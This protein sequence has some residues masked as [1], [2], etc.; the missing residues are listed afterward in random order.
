[1]ANGS[2]CEWGS[3]ESTGKRDRGAVTWPSR[4]WMLCVRMVI[5]TLEVSS[6]REHE[7]VQG[8]WSGDVGA[9]TQ[10]LTNFETKQK[11]GSSL[12]H[13]KLGLWGTS[14][15]VAFAAVNT[16]Q[17]WHV[18]QRHAHVKVLVLSREDAWWWADD[19]R[20]GEEKI[21]KTSQ[22]DSTDDYKKLMRDKLQQLI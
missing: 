5:W 13:R 2:C 19:K 1:M 20:K 7:V 16:L 22:S 14:G 18:R 6:V 4:F 21:T 3:V 9:D 10:E 15:G 17:M 8:R 11:R 12:K